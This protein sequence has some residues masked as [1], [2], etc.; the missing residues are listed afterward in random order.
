MS[1]KR[2]K[3]MSAREFSQFT[4]AQKCPWDESQIAAVSGLVSSMSADVKKLMEM[5]DDIS[6]PVGTD[7]R[8]YATKMIRS[9]A[10]AHNGL[11]DIS[12]PIYSKF[13]H[14]APET[15]RTIFLPDPTEESSDSTP[16]E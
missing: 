6:G 7:E 16:K 4:E 13:P 10:E 8:K 11:Q 14:L 9:V 15:W 2:I 1:E 5:I 3:D 12:R